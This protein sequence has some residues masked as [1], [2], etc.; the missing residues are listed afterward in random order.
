[1]DNINTYLTKCVVEKHQQRYI[2]LTTMTIYYNYSS[3]YNFDVIKILAYPRFFTASQ[4]KKLRLKTD[5]V[6]VVYY[7]H[8]YALP[9]NL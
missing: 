4:L 7:S 2:I 1:M 6:I 9:E 8:Q 5:R 3:K